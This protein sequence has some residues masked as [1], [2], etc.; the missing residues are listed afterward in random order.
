MPDHSYFENLICRSQI[1]CGEPI[2]RRSM[3]ASCCH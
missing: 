1:S 2:N 3:S